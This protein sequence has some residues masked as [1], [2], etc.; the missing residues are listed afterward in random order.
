MSRILLRRTA[1]EVN[2]GGMSEKNENPLYDPEVLQFWMK[3]GINPVALSTTSEDLNLAHV[4]H[5]IDAWEEAELLKELDAKFSV[6]DFCQDDDPKSLQNRL[7]RFADSVSQTAPPAHEQYLMAEK[8]RR[9]L[10]GSIRRAFRLE[11]HARSKHL[12]KWATAFTDLELGYIA[13]LRH[14]APAK[15]AFLDGRLRRILE[16]KLIMGR[17]TEAMQFLLRVFGSTKGIGPVNEKWKA[18]LENPLLACK[19]WTTPTCPLW[20]LSGEVGARLLRR[21]GASVDSRERFNTLVNDHHL[22]RLQPFRVDELLVKTAPESAKARRLLQEL[23]R[24]AAIPDF[25]FSSIRAGR[26]KSGG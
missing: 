7:I 9:E 10:T 19:M 16:T 15:F 24:E 6:S 25:S 13:R 26:P 8:S 21:Q 12:K 17:G 3:M 2:S 18:P 11:I 4:W 20:M 23:E 5:Q 1:T 14:L 22:I